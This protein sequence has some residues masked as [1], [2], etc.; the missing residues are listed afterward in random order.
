MLH[1]VL[2]PQPD[3]RENL[4]RVGAFANSRQKLPHRFVNVIAVANGLSHRRARARAAQRFFNPLAEAFVVRIEVE[5]IFL[6]VDAIAGLVSLKQSLEEPRRVA[7]VPAW[8][9][10][11]FSGLDDV[12]FDFER[13]DD[14]HGLRS[15]PVEQFDHRFDFIDRSKLCNLSNRHLSSCENVRQAA[16]LSLLLEV[17]HCERHDKLEACRTATMHFH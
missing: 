9:T 5:E 1:L 6:A 16:S 11:R 3:E 14:Q 12:I 17:A 15:N 2:K 10:H 13:S 7:D 8:R 4:L